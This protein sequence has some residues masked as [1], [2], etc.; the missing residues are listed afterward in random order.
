M[1]REVYITSRKRYSS[2]SPS[3]APLHFPLL[4]YMFTAVAE[5]VACWRSIWDCIWNA[6]PHR[7]QNTLNCTVWWVFIH[8]KYR[9]NSTFYCHETNGIE[10]YTLFLLQQCDWLTSIWMTCF[11]CNR[12][13]SCEWCT[14]VKAVQIA[15]LES[16][17]L[18]CK[19]VIVVY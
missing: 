15:F 19:D 1:W 4:S 5:H 12:T 11:G 14:C 2:W 3:R 8:T 7:I 10:I 13:G 9:R 6:V 17:V 16:W 18:N